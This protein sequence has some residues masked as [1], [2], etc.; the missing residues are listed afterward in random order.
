MATRI[1]GVA[2]LGSL[3]AAGKA[4]VTFDR[5]LRN[6]NTITKLS[7][8]QLEALSKQI[9]ALSKTSGKGP[10]ELSDAMYDVASSGFKANDALTILKVT[11]KAAT[12]GMTDTK[13]ATK[14]VVSVLNAYHLGAD[15]A[16]KTADILF[17]TVEKGVL[18]FEELAAQIGDV[19]PV[20]AQLGVP[21][22]DVGGALATITLHGVSAAEAST[23]LKQTLVSILKPSDALAATMKTWGFETGE[24]AL[25]TLGLEGFMRKL[26]VSSKG[27]AAAF[28][29]FFPNVRAMSGALGI[30]GK[31][32]KTLHD[33][34]EAMSRR[35]AAAAAFAE[36]GKSISVMWDK[37]KASMIAA[38]IPIGQMLFPALKGG[39]DAVADFAQQ[40]EMHMPTIRAQFG[41]IASAAEG[42]GRALASVGGSQGGQIA[43]AG[44]LSA[45]AGG[46]ATLGIQNLIQSLNKLNPIVGG[47]ALIVGLFGAA[48]YAAAT[49]VDAL[50]RASN[51]A[52]EA[53][54]KYKLSLDGQAQAHLNVRH[55]SNQLEAALFAQEAAQSLATKAARESGAGS[56]QHKQALLNVRMANDQVAQATLNRKS[57]IEAAK[58]ADADATKG[59]GKLRQELKELRAEGEGL[60]STTQKVIAGNKGATSS[61][62]ETSAAQKSDVTRRYAK[63]MAGLQLELGNS[64]NQARLAAEAVML[65]TR[66]LGRLPTQKQIDIFINQHGSAD[67]RG[68]G[69]AGTNRGG[70]RGQ[71]GPSRA[72]G[73]FVPGGPG[74]AVPILAHAG[75]VILN[76]TQ[77][78]ALGGAGEIAR[79]FGF[80]G[81]R[82]PSFAAGGFVGRR[83]LQIA[84]AKPS[85]WR[86]LRTRS[87]SASGAARSALTAVE[88]VNQSQSNLDRMYGQLAR[89]FDISQEQFLV[90]GPNG[91]QTVDGA[92]IAQRISEI[93]RLSS[94][95]DSMLALIDQEKAELEKAIEKLRQAIK[96]LQAA[97]RAEIRAARAD[98]LAIKRLEGKKKRT[99]ADEA[100][101][102]RLRA[103]ESGHRAT[104]ETYKGRVSEFN[105]ALKGARSDLVNVVPFDR[106]DV[107]LDLMELAAERRLVSGTIAP[108]SFGGDGGSSGG[109]ISDAISGSVGTPAVDVEELLRTIGQLR[110]A[111]GIEGV[112]MP[113][114]GSFQKGALHV[115]ETG[116]A[117][118][119]AGE[120]ITPSGVPRGGGGSDAPIVVNV[121][122]HGSLEALAP[123]I[124]TRID[125]ATDRISVNIGSASD[126]RRR[127]GGF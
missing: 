70:S 106:R 28:A 97:I 67:V 57:A 107:E 112:Q 58:R 53:A 108:A 45:F 64:E 5:S 89:E 12:A 100:Q 79:M 76:Q 102:N 80:H 7:E 35:G 126:R 124:D 68:L 96:D 84:R 115:A 21:L 24:A 99:K 37:A 95:R 118:V 101:L 119:H 87:K 32:V 34:I 94:S 82:G 55:A 11:S 9:L 122:L 4:A 54:A 16:S 125:G 113:I 22:E 121:G 13:T 25:K 8:K 88:A 17:S 116:L 111:L 50:T 66:Q 39:A 114:I 77:Q 23:Q 14:A 110:L 85:P 104:A 117:L 123:Y 90:D 15:K 30:T 38:A 31:N 46:K 72:L 52:A 65:L 59:A 49:S 105:D 92:A 51:A 47:A 56:V 6:L 81:D 41:E 73:G 109:G 60:F 103:S 83:G 63:A 27:S 127:A 75:E 44:F 29:E 69:G 74:Q 91:T 20:A 3:V 61:F 2:M 62:V 93:D 1:I 48:A 120:Q 71:G 43:A 42:V 36:Q 78:A 40:V 33:N 86:K 10:T 18:T 26:T 98:A 19:L